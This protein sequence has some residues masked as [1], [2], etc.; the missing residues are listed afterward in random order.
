MKTLIKPEIMLV[1]SHF[2]SNYH[3]GQFSRGYSYSCIAM[4]YLRNEL[5][6]THPL[7]IKLTGKR[8]KL[9]NYLVKNYADKM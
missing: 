1:L 6:I 3:S 5:D 7:D 4:R 8:K 9:Y 2:C